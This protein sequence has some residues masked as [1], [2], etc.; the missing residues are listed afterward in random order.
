MTNQSPPPAVAELL[1]YSHKVTQR[2]AELAAQSACAVGGCRGRPR[3]IRLNQFASRPV[4]R[5][6]ARLATTV[7]HATSPW[8]N[9]FR[10][11]VPGL[12]G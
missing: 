7:A 10:R 8:V 2:H 11:F 1:G 9:C 6:C 4:V 5:A 3:G 12:R